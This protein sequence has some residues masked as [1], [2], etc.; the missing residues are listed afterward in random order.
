MDLVKCNVKARIATGAE[1]GQSE[2]QEAEEGH[3]SK[4]LQTATG[5]TNQL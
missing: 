5:T 1:E 4:D 2:L 3:G